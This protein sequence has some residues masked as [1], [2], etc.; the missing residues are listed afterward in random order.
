M[1]KAYNHLKLKVLF[2]VAFFL[3][4]NA[5]LF[6]NCGKGFQANSKNSANHSGPSVTTTTTPQPTTGATPTPSPT[7]IQPDGIEYTYSAVIYSASAL[8]DCGQELSPTVGPVGDQ[9]LVDDEQDLLYISDHFG[10]WKYEINGLS[11]ASHGW[12]DKVG[13]G[14]RC[15]PDPSSQIV[16]D[17]MTVTVDSAGCGSAWAQSLSF[18]GG[19]EV[20]VILPDDGGRMTGLVIFS[21]LA[22]SPSVALELLPRGSLYDKDCTGNYCEPFITARS[23]G[24]GHAVVGGPPAI[25]QTG[26]FALPINNGSRRF[27]VFFKDA[28]KYTGNRLD[29]SSL[30]KARLLE[31]TDPLSPIDHGAISDHSGLE[32]V[33]SLMCPSSFDCKFDRFLI[34]KHLAI[35]KDGD[36]K[37]I[38]FSDPLNVQ[39]VSA[40]PSGSGVDFEG[41]AYG[42]RW[43]ASPMR[44]TKQLTYA[45][46]SLYLHLLGELDVGGSAC[47]HLV[48]PTMVPKCYKS[49]GQ[50]YSCCM[51]QIWEHKIGSNTTWQRRMDTPAQIA[52]IKDGLAFSYPAQRIDNS[53]LYNHQGKMLHK[54]VNY[55][56]AVFDLESGSLHEAVTLPEPP[57]AP[58]KKSTPVYLEQDGK[59]YAIERYTAISMPGEPF[60]LFS[61]QFVPK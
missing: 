31:F 48:N 35:V 45:D 23:G 10:V 59:Y 44:N 47:S 40:I 18:V 60:Y 2:A 24:E 25:G 13:W 8:V 50:Y 26:H 7:P 27:S 54:T 15:F 29:Q 51:G 55:E 6:H 21:N 42:L 17:C 37:V 53:Q 16:P 32:K 20:S 34:N 39:E 43:L 5:L 58:Y 38:D 36:H 30:G 28:Y 4:V 9:M 14:S 41:V 11:M 52:F 57:N 19:N 49:G 1:K 3:C 33:L 12:V 56:V 61:H 46:G 22:S